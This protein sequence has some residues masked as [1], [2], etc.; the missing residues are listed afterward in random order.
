MRS[1][2]VSARKALGTV[3][4]LRYLC[5][6]GVPFIQV[7]CYQQLFWPRPGQLVL[8]VALSILNSRSSTNEFKVPILC[9]T[10]DSWGNLYILYLAVFLSI[11]QVAFYARAEVSFR[12]SVF[13]IKRMKNDS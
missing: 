4:D 11:H 1:G 7:S 8:I 9:G 5:H 12:I 13:R 3:P 6:P 2:G 10:E